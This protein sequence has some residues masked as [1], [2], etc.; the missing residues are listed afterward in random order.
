MGLEIRFSLEKL[1]IVLIVILVPLNFIGLYLTTQ[2]YNV[3]QQNT[4]TLFRNIAENDAN[5]AFRFLNDR[6]T[7]IA[8]LASH[9]AIMDAILASNHKWARN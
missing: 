2:C 7:S 4:G 1:L 9:Q 8:D 3:V 5:A 6:V